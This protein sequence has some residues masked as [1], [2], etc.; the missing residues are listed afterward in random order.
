MYIKAF[1]KMIEKRII[2][3]KKTEWKTGIECFNWWINNKEDVTEDDNG[4]LFL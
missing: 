4:G 2:D 3:G 1:D